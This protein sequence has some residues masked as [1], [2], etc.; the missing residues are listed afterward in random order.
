MHFNFHTR[1]NGTQTCQNVLL[2]SHQSSEYFPRS[3][4]EHQDD[5][6]GNKRRGFLH[7]FSAPDASHIESSSLD[8]L[9]SSIDTERITLLSF[10]PLGLI[11]FHLIPYN[12]KIYT[13]LA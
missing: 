6:L 7:D 2:L 4:G 10:S 12:I 11:C 13:T 3:L 5:F 1:H 9:K 8:S